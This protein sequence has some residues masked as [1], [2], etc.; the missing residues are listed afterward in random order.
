VDSDSVGRSHEDQI[1]PALYST[2]RNVENIE[3]Q[4]D[5]PR[6]RDMIALECVAE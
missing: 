6:D 2:A 5:L 4:A 1:D 3:D